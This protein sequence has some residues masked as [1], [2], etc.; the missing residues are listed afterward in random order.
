LLADV[1]REP[2]K[3]NESLCDYQNVNRDFSGG[4]LLAP[5]SRALESAAAGPP[6]QGWMRRRVCDRIRNMPTTNVNI[7]EAA[8]SLSKA[9]SI[10]HGPFKP[11]TDQIIDRDIKLPLVKLFEVV[12]LHNQALEK[13]QMELERLASH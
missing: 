9:K 4:E 7:S 12:D 2:G 8:A 13:L 11:L 3:G 1:N 10:I 6:T 5:S